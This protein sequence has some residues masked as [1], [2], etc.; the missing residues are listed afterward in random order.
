MWGILLIQTNLLLDWLTRLVN[1]RLFFL[2]CEEIWG[3]GGGSEHIVSHYLCDKRCAGR[4]GTI[5]DNQAQV[6]MAQAWTGN[7]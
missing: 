5:G 2:V 1:W 3:A 6:D 7:R 4:Q